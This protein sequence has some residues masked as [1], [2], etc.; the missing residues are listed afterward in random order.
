[1]M[2]HT[3][4]Q[5]PLSDSNRGQKACTVLQKFK[6]I[7]VVEWDGKQLAGGRGGSE[8]R[9]NGVGANKLCDSLSFC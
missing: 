7:A 2:M 3:S 9:A 1:M 4:A 6:L 8:G 5:N